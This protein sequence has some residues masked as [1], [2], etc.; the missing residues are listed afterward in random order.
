VSGGEANGAGETKLFGWD[1]VSFHVPRAWDLAVYQLKR[2]FTRIEFDDDYTTRLEAEWIRPKR[3]LDIRR[4]QK[5]YDKNARKLNQD[6]EKVQRLEGL[7]EGW[8]AVLYVMPEGERL[9]TA[10]LLN[11]VPR[12]FASVL[13]HFGP[14]DKEDAERV[15]RDLAGSFRVH[16]E[17]VVPW[18]LYDLSLELPAAFRLAYTDFQTGQKLLVFQWRLRRLFLW[19]VS[20]AHLILKR[21]PAEVW[22]TDLFNTCRLIRGPV[23]FRRPDGRVDWKRRLRHHFGHHDELARWCFQ[24]RTGF[25]HDPGLDRIVAW[26]YS[27]RKPDDLTM[28]ERVRVESRRLEVH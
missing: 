21:H 19:H 12:L 8:V 20:V 6:A 13:L 10:F 27:Y 14:K 9:L 28:L 5:R 7:P 17:E 16:D 4:I 15:L 2:T 26:V 18:A 1:C 23:F 3:D 11:S 22:V 25:F 24:Y